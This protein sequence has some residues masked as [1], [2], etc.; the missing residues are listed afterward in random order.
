MKSTDQAYD[1]MRLNFDLAKPPARPTLYGTGEDGKAIL[2]W[3]NK[4]E[5]S[6]DPLTQV[7]DFEG[8]RIYRSQDHGVNWKLLG[9]FDLINT[10]GS[11]RGLQYSYTDTTVINGFEYWYTVTAY[12]RGGDGIGSLESPK[13]NTL[14]A[15]NTVAI[16]PLSA[17]SG[18]IPVSAG[19]IEYSGTD[20][21]PTNYYLNIQPFD[22]EALAGRQYQ[23]GFTY[24]LNKEKG[25]LST[26]VSYE[27]YDSSLTKAYK[28]GILFT[29]AT[30]YDIMNLNTNE[31]IGRENYN[32]P[33]GGRTIK[34]DGHGLTLHLSDSAGTPADK[35]PE[36]GDLITISF[37]LY[38]LNGNGDTVITPHPLDIGKNQATKDGVIF[39]L[40]PPQIIKSVSRIG[41]TD[42]VDITF[43]VGDETL[44]K[45]NF[46]FVTVESNGFNSSNE[47]FVSLS[48]R[49]TGLILNIDTLYSGDTF[50]FQGIEGTISFP[51]ADPPSAG[52]KFSVESCKT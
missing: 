3:D 47:G 40:N 19:T 37:S 49:D 21:T 32:Y 51:D 43:D 20:P 5:S 42:N 33:S 46:Y 2:Y 1:A 4:A 24:L 6:I 52:N 27:I 35:L 9:D 10:I 38:A 41:G 16:T 8:Y 17:P 50:S 30:T 29:S 11:N 45:N 44:I 13:G 12:D 25:D 39:S 34:I 18:R 26:K 36:A 15:I 23:I 22:D 48:V 28:Y 7:Q 31:I 14:D